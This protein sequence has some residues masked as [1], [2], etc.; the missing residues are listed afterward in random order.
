ML[1]TYYRT[2][3]L[4]DTDAAGVIYFA[5]LLS[6]CHEAYEAALETAGI[7]FKALLNERAIAIPIVRCSADFWQP[8]FCGDRLSLCLNPKFLSEN[9]FEIDYQIDCCSSSTNSVAKANTRHVCI[10]PSTRRRTQ[11]PKSLAECLSALIE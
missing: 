7:S 4:G 10:D 1:F 5:Q 11:L 8:I 6:I 3:R 9:E 2:V